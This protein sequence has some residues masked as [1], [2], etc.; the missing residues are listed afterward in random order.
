MNRLSN[1]PALTPALLAAL[2]SLAAPGC[3][4]RT[5]LTSGGSDAADAADGA[6]A[7]DAADASSE[8]GT[9]SSASDDGGTPE[10]TAGQSTSDG[11]SDDAGDDA[12]DDTGDGTEDVPQPLVMCDFWA[13]DC[14][15][16]QKC[17]AASSNA[18]DY[19]W[20]MH[21]CVDAGTEPPGAPCTKVEGADPYAA[22]DTCDATGK[23]Y[24]MNPDTGIG[25]CVEMC[26]GNPQNATCP[27][28]NWDCMQKASI[29]DLCIPYCTPVPEA[30]PEC[31]DCPLDEICVAEYEGDTLD[32]FICFPPAAEGI[33]GES[34]EC[35][36]CCAAGLM[37]TDAA[38]YGQGCAYDLCCTEYCDITDLAFTC[39]GPDQQCVA[40]FEP[41]RPP[42][43]QRGRLHGAV[44]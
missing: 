21:I 28:T 32:H 3:T 25:T 44:N 19:P 6:E 20:N 22:T 14:P 24:R 11:S 15:E 35:A 13:Q 16:G 23:C 17:T 37:C 18:F 27:I 34:C 26:V 43:R 2:L 41:C 7:A 31:W 40:L 30:C 12:G 39:A 1:I 9:S 36:N 10:T 38:T 33:T 4:A 42:L 8:A 29:F 5:G